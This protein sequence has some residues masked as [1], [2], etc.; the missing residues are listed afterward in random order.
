MTN[1]ASEHIRSNVSG[2]SAAAVPSSPTAAPPW[3]R[4]LGCLAEACGTAASMSLLT[5]P[6][7]PTRRR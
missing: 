1:R 7:A 4:F 2:L 6:R 3:A 5:P